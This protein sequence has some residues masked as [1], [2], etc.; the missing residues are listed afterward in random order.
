MSKILFRIVIYLVVTA[1]F[2]ATVG[3]VIYVN[4]FEERF[5]FE[6]KG[7]ENIGVVTSTK[8]T[9]KSMD[10]ITHY[11]EGEPY[12]V[13]F[14]ALPGLI[15]GERFQLLYNPEDPQDAIVQRWHPVFLNSEARTMK[16]GKL[17]YIT[18]VKFGTPQPCMS[19]EYPAGFGDTLQKMQGLPMN[20]K[21]RYPDLTVGQHYEVEYWQENP[22]RAI[23]YLDRPVEKE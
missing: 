8:G 20:Y 17:I 9:S 22:K 3:G 18:D 4:F 5:D 7:I 1:G 21:T 11:V 23:I 19:F 15:I 12:L 16:V 10:G 6:N 13:G 14:I 2:L